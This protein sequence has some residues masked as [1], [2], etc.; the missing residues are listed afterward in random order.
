MCD[1]LMISEVTRKDIPD[2]KVLGANMGPNWGRKDPGGPHVGH[3]NLAIWDAT[4][5]HK[6]I[7]K[8]YCLNSFG[9][10]FYSLITFWQLYS[11][12]CGIMHV[13]ILFT[14]LSLFKAYWWINNDRSVSMTGFPSSTSFIFHISESLRACLSENFYLSYQ[15][16]TTH[17]TNPRVVPSRIFPYSLEINPLTYWKFIVAFYLSRK[18]YNITM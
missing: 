15:I 7:W 17:A 16:A 18:S 5:K 8:K 9:R 12:A 6:K 2:S 3:M 11:S 10:G 4:T 13:D 1:S 14:G